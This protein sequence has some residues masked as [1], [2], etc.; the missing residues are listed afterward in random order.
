[1]SAM[2]SKPMAVRYRGERSNVVITVSS[3]RSNRCCHLLPACIRPGRMR[4]LAAISCK[5]I[6]AKRRVFKGL[7]KPGAM[8]IAAGLGKAASASSRAGTETSVFDVDHLE[9]A[10]AGRRAHAD[11]LVHGPAQKRSGN[12]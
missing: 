3:L 12:G 1:M 11:L 9:H 10:L 7:V 6:G 5:D 8:A 2:R 4:P